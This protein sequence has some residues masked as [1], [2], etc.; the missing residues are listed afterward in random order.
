MPCGPLREVMDNALRAVA[1]ALRAG[2]DAIVAAN[3]GDL[4]AGEDG[5]YHHICIQVQAPPHVLI[6]VERLHW[7]RTLLKECAISLEPVEISERNAITNYG[8]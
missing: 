2:T 4:V 7:L 6:R 1:V 3:H 8:T 5:P